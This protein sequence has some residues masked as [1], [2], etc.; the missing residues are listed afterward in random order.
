MLDSPCSAMVRLWNTKA[1]LRKAPRLFYDDY[2]PKAFVCDLSAR[3]A[4]HS[5]DFIYA[6]KSAFAQI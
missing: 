1:N 2:D 6:N 4:C 3:V 5:P